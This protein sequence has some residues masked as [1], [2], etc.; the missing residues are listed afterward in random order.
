MRSIVRTDEF[1]RELLLVEPDVARSDEF[2]E[3]VEWLLSRD[4]VAGLQLNNRVWSLDTSE[5]ALIEPLTVYY[6]FDDKRVWLLAI[7]RPIERP[8]D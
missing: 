1:E 2:L 3:G 4:P 5:F 6:T 7:R 8:E